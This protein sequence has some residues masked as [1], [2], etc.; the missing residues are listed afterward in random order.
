MLDGAARVKPHAFS[1]YA[2][3]CLPEPQAHKTWNAAC[4]KGMPIGPVM[5]PL[6][7][8]LPTALVIVVR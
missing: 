4:P 2:R 3:E 1:Q 5:G 6:P 8:H 7:S